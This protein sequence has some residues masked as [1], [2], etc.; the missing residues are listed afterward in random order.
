MEHFKML[1]LT[2]NILAVILCIMG[3]VASRNQ[4][5]KASAGLWATACGLMAVTSIMHQWGG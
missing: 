3:I 1:P 4:N 5:Y 2:I